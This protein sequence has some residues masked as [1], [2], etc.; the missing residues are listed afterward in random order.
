MHET[1]DALTLIH[2]IFELWF[3]SLHMCKCG[4]NAAVQFLDIIQYNMYSADLLA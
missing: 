4:W 1:N 2:T 3:T